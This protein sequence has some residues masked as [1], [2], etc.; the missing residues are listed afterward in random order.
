GAGALRAVEASALAEVLHRLSTRPRLEAVRELADELDRL[1]QAGIPGLKLRD[2]LTL[3]TLDVRL[4]RPERWVSATDAT[5]GITRGMDWRAVL[6]ALGYTL[7]QRHQRGHLAR[8]EGRPV[9]VVHPKADPSQL[10]RLDPDGR[11]P[12]GMLPRTGVAGPHRRA[13]RMGRRRRH[14]RSEL[15]ANFFILEGLVVPDLSDEDYQAVAR[16]AARLS[17]V[18]ERFADFAR[19]TG[20]DCG[21]LAEDQSEELRVEIDAR[22]ARAWEL[23]PA[24]LEVMFADFTLDAVPLAYRRALG[25]GLEAL[26][27]GAR[28]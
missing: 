23:D 6:S 25:E 16:A 2:L 3:H 24:D 5:K 15:H 27:G 7:E 18:D 1:D 20:V 21:P 9:L 17:C 19:S 13:A 22:V 12:E 11:P 8:F 14:S 4:R 28:A 26:R 10:S